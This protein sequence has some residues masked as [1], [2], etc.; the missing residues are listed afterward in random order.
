MRTIALLGAP[1][2]GKTRLANALAD[3]LVKGDGQ[4]GDCN[5]PITIVD[6]YV[7]PV[8]DNFNYEIGLNGGY[9]ATIS[10][11][12]E[13]YNQERVAGYDGCKTMISCG[14]VVESSVYLAQY[15][16][17]SMSLLSSDEDLI[18]EAQR[19]EGSVKMLAVL[20]Q[21]TFKYEKA[22]YLPPLKPNSDERWA[23][24]DRNLQAAFS[25]FEVPVAPLLVED[26]KDGDDLVRQQVERVLS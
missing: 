26:Y 8:R 9:M 4:C 6:N 3:E 21:D 11:A 16:E 13:R 25:A 23:T 5:T 22:F 2:A 1:G 14:T 12:V 7:N 20:Y 10:I 24:F 19:I 17:R 15:F 18:E